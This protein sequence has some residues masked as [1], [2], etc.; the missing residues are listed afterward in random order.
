MHDA[1]L[2]DWD[3]FGKIRQAKEKRLRDPADVNETIGGPVSMCRVTIFSN[4]SSN[5]R[6]D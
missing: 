1:E 3:R 2:Q 5:E 6:L 4:I